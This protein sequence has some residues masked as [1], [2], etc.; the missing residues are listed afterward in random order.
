MNFG[1]DL[2]FAYA[3]DTNAYQAHTTQENIMEPVQKRS[4]NQNTYIQPSV[5]TSG[6]GSG[7][8]LSMEEQLLLLKKELVKEKQKEKKNDASFISRFINKKKEMIKIFV[9]ALIILLAI[10]IHFLVKHYLKVYIMENDF[11]SK[12]EFLIRFSYPL[13]VFVIIWIMKAYKSTDII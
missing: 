7:N 3:G 13:T 1:S 5:Q 2:N 6:A 12:K 9:L 11:N 10:S 8:N 4:N